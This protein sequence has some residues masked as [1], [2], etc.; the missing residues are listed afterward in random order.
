MGLTEPTSPEIEGVP[1][2]EERSSAAAAQTTESTSADVEG[3]TD[4]EETAPTTNAEDAASLA[5]NSRE[6]P[7]GELPLGEEETPVVEAAATPVKGEG[8]P[9]ADEVAE[10]VVADKTETDVVAD[11]GPAP[12]EAVIV[13]D[14]GGAHLGEWMILGVCSWL[15][16]GFTDALHIIDPRTVYRGK[17]DQTRQDH[18]Q[19][20]IQP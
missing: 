19:R 6:L 20:Q 17:K 1:A 7:L 16:D 2:D 8:M 14:E 11:V 12:E 9:E 10:A 4:G 15:Q 18:R 5:N 3:A 13:E